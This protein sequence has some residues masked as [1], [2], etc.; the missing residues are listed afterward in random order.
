MSKIKKSKIKEI[1]ELYKKVQEIPYYCLKERD[2]DLL[3]KKGKG[4][5]DEKHLFLGKE[6]EKLGVPVKYLVLRFDWNDLAIPKEII[7]KKEDGSIGWHLALM[8][9]PKDKWIYVDATW[10][11]KLKKAGFPVTENWSGLSNTKFA[12][13]PKEIIELNK[14]L[15]K[16][17]KRYENCE[18]Y[19]ALNKWLES[20][21]NQNNSTNVIIFHGAFGHPKE[22]WLPWLKSKLEK[23]GC[24]VYIPKFPTPKNQNLKNWLKVF[25]NYQ[26]YLNK[27]SILI[28]HSLGV[29]FILNILERLNYPVKASFLV[30]GFIGLL[31]N[32][33]FDKINKT[34]TNRQFKWQKIKQNC[35]KF[36]IYTSDNDPYIPIE[37]GKEISKNLKVKPKTIKGAGH[38]NKAAGYDKFELLLK[39][40]KNLFF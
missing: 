7:E 30:A 12:F 35:K 2:P 4:S 8:I 38:F 25:R 13:P 32:P 6:F 40:I 15:P 37:K 31:N 16:Q 3:L 28:G 14:R 22:N 10:D 36:Y 23:L 5:C 27:N 20:Q 9:K 21:R 34:I 11:P 18:F 24:E 29:A 26:Q 39:D 19:E 33:V 1:I 17:V